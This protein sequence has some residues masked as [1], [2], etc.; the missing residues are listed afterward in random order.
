MV[1]HRIDDAIE[2]ADRVI[3]LGAKARIR[4]EAAVPSASCIGQA[5]DRLRHDIEAALGPDDPE[6]ISKSTGDKR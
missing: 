6:S 1:T 4:L 3:V 2:M 5:R